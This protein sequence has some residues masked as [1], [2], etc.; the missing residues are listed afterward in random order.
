MP[1]A[2]KKPCR[3][4]GCSGRAERDG[5]CWPCWAV[6][7]QPERRPDTRPSSYERGYD[8]KWRRIRAQFLR[9][10]SVCVECGAEA[11][12][13][14]H[15]IPLAQGGTHQWNNLQPLCHSCHS[16][17]TA[18]RDGGFGNGL[19]SRNKPRA[20]KTY[21]D[22]SL[23][24]RNK[25]N[26]GSQTC[27]HVVGGTATGKS[28]VLGLLSKE[29]GMPTFSI[30]EERAKLI[31]NEEWVNDEQELA[32]WVALE[33][34]ID[35]VE[36]AAVE[37]SGHNLNANVM[38][39]GRKVFTIL[40]VASDS[41]RQARLRERVE[42]GYSLPTGVGMAERLLGFIDYTYVDKLMKIGRPDLDA[43]FIWDSEKDK[44]ELTEQL[45]NALDLRGINKHWGGG[46]TN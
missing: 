39:D 33:D 24:T 28:Y 13:V 34:A 8:H 17:K 4:R 44:D 31:F 43:D 5:F 10:H 21:K 26:R 22:F 6:R 16:R 45:L 29:L 46:I 40:C 14:D 3:N 18:K 1:H 11:N 42:K 15:I 23:R 12:H 25:N 36:I 9:R 35:N 7:P 37:T 20:F 38:L 30:D 27:V 19:P 2:P 41:A 32:A